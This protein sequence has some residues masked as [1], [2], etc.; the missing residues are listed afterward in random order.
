MPS[1][2]APRYRTRQEISIERFLSH[3]SLMQIIFAVS[4]FKQSLF[5]T[6]DLGNFLVLTC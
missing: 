1:S 5:P 4:N 2:L 3:S 6:F